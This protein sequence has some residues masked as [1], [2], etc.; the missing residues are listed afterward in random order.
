MGGTSSDFPIMLSFL[1]GGEVVDTLFL[2]LLAGKAFLF[3]GVACL[4]FPLLSRFEGSIVRILENVVWMILRRPVRTLCS[5]L[6]L[7]FCLLFAFGAA[8]AGS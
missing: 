1:N 5:I 6:L 2:G 7:I 3:L 4:C 8:V